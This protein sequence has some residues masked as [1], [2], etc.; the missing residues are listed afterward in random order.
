[1]GWPSRS[2]QARAGC[3]LTIASA[4]VLAG[5]GHLLEQQLERG[6]DGYGDESPMRPS[7]VPPINV[8]MMVRPGLTLTVCF[9]T[10]GFNR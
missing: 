7:R 3:P 10:L 9:I 6:S 1:V 2:P 8:A 5:D 4:L